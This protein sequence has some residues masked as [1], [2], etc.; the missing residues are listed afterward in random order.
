MDFGKFAPDHSKIR[1]SKRSKKKLILGSAALVLVLAVSF[2]LYQTS[3]VLTI[4]GSPSDVGVYQDFE[5][6]KEEDRLDILVLGIRGSGDPNGGLLADT[7]LLVSF[8]KKDNKIAMVSLPRDLYV[9]MPDHPNP[10]KINFAYALGEQR[11]PGGGGLTLSKEVVKYITGVY[12]DHAVVVNFHGFERL[13]NIMGGVNIYRST[14]FYESK[15]WQGE[16]KEG[17][18]FWYKES[19]SAE[20]SDKQQ[21]TSENTNETT[22]IEEQ[23]EDS[24]DSTAATAPTPIPEEPQEEY[25]V[26]HV[27]AG[28]SNL[29]GESALYYVRSRYSSSDFDRMR[30]QQQVIDSLKTKA[31]SL[32]VVANPVKVFD[33]LDTI[34]AN[35]RTDMGLGDIRE[36]I[37][38]AQKYQENDIITGQLDTSDDGLLVSGHERG[39]YVLVPKTGD[40]SQI[41]NYFQTI[42]EEDKI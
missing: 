12:V 19:A 28:S 7:M 9:E 1:D 38:L 16:G 24:G 39:M 25:W 22:N 5:V 37:S 21:E 18:P 20:A 10:E 41:R 31:T 2:F 35:M 27:P 11:M 40:F 36:A 3:N 23:Q 30:R 17:S 26:F 42:F 33:I 13:V 34:G 4:A 8:D 6:E 15:Q 14:D 29:D 32:G